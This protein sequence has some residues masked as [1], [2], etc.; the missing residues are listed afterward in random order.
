MH[1]FINRWFSS[2]PVND[3]IS[4]ESLPSSYTCHRLALTDIKWLINKGHNV[5]VEVRGEDT[6]KKKE[7]VVVGVV[8][9][10]VMD[11]EEGRYN[12]LVES[13]EGLVRVGGVD[14]YAED[15]AA[16]TIK[17]WAN[18]ELKP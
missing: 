15:V 7:R 8:K 5:V 6:K 13:K 4:P 9:E 11:A 3:Y 12:M 18:D 14:A 10:V 1:N 16:K 17:V 2:K